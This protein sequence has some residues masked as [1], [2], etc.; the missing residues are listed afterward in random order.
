[1]QKKISDFIISFIFPYLCGYKKGF[2]TQQALLTLV[3][4]WRKRLDNKDFGGAILMD[5]SKA[6]DT[7]DH[8]RPLNCKTTCIWFLTRR[9]K[10]SLY[11]FLSYSTEP[12]L[13]KTYFSS[14]EK[15]IKGV[16]QGSASGQI[17]FNL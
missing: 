1:M 15:L 13:K 4:N 14:W 9:F 10:T 16:S 6:F 17:L 2:N 11:T 12:K 7:L 5:L 3:E 8:F